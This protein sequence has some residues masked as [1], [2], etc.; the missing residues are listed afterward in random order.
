MRP[1]EAVA[2]TE[3]TNIVNLAWTTVSRA[4]AAKQFATVA[5][6]NLL[7]EIMLS[8]VHDY[9]CA[10]CDWCEGY[11]DEPRFKSTMYRALSCERREINP[12]CV[13]SCC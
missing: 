12:Q 13:S 3:A 10:D 8:C 6:W 11:L 5:G 2:V 7:V 1:R 4:N 9:E